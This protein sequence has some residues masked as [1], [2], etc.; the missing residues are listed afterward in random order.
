LSRGEVVQAGLAVAHRLGLESLTLKDVAQ[1]LGITPAAVLWYVRTKDELLDAI[2]DLALRDLAPPERSN[3]PWAEELH[4]V[5]V[6]LRKKVL[7]NRRIVRA[8]AFRRGAP[9]AF[10]QIAFTSG[11]I[12][13]D[14]GFAEE[15]V[16]HAIRTLFW[17][18]L[19]LSAL[20][21][22]LARD[23]ASRPTRSFGV[24]HV[25]AKLGRDDLE[26]LDPMAVDVD[27][28][29]AYSFGKLLSGLEQQLDRGRR[30]GARARKV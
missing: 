9:L 29:F 19:G 3:G 25:A 5:F 24:R 13:R 6:A 23:S 1:E 28:L 12:L 8:G 2:V 22:A 11:Q 14:A 16:P 27:D 18:T 17:H 10:V 30:V 4:R 26:E 7:E 15:V 20:E 21:I